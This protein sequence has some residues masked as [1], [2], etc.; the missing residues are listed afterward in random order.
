M[1]RWPRIVAGARVH[2]GR[3]PRRE[4]D[5]CFEGFAQCMTDGVDQTL[6]FE[7]RDVSAWAVAEPIALGY[8]GPNPPDLTGYELVYV[9]L[10]VDQMEVTGTEGAYT[11]HIQMRWKFYGY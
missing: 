11:V 1:D 9:E 6:A 2:T 7:V 4:S 10:E 5:P 3:E 8:G